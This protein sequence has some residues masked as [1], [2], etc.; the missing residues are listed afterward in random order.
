MSDHDL[1]KL[2]WETSKVFAPSFPRVSASDH[3]VQHERRSRGE[4]VAALEATADSEMPGY[5]SVYSFPRGHPKHDNIPEIDTIFVDLDVT[6]DHYD[7]KHGRTSEESWRADMSALLVRARMI[8]RA[9]L[10]SGKAEHFRVALSG[11]KGI[12]LYFDIE[13]IPP[14]NGAKQQFK[15]GLGK[16]GEQLMAWLDHA[17]GGLNI[18]RWVDVDASDLSRLARHPNTRHHGVA[19]TDDPRWCV[20]VT[21]A[22]LA[23]MTVDDYIELTSSPRPLP[24]GYARSPSPTASAKAE[25]YVREASAANITASNGGAVQTKRKREA[26]AEYREE[27]QD[28][29]IT[30]DDVLFLT[31]NKPC[32]QA[33]RER[34][35]AYEHGKQSRVMELSIMG[36][37]LD[38]R[39]PLDVIHEFFEPIPGYREGA[40]GEKN[41]TTDILA[42]LLSRDNEYGEFNC[43]TIAGGTGADG[44]HVAGQAP[45]FCL[46]EACQLYRRSDDIDLPDHYA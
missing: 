30:L 24:D 4:F 1:G 7:P 2:L 25:Q 19:Y 16:F 6:K 5:Y 42:D 9:L 34:S 26:L 40:V 22:E 20:P 28:D 38:M 37:L 44:G 36:R 8:A 21:V 27:I 35:D 39:V 18:E 33:F 13:P 17:A 45:E 32:F 23:E 10:E 12:H 15:N 31:K 14:A 46:G 29:D 43:V 11:H 41:T 3:T